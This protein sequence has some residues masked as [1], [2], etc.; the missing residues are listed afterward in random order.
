MAQLFLFADDLKLH[1]RDPEK[2]YQE[3]L[4]TINKFSNAA[5]YR[6]NLLKLIAFLYTIIEHKEITIAPKRIKYLGINLTK[7]VTFTILTF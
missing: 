4:E 7:E 2:F 3:T 1:I 5:E 6:I